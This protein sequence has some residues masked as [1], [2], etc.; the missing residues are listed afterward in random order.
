MSTVAHLSEPQDRVPRTKSGSPW[1]WVL[2]ILAVLAGLTIMLV[3][4]VF[5]PSGNA[6]YPICLFHRTTGLLCP[7]CGSLR[8]LHQLLHGHISEAFYYNPM[9]VMGIPVMIWFG[10]LVLVGR[11]RQT[12]VRIVRPGKWVWLLVGVVLAFSIWRNVPGT[13]FAISGP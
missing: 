6:F 3:L 13:P 1:V 5:D 9:L 2:P 4:F 11:L 10:W 8:A 12:P 7:G